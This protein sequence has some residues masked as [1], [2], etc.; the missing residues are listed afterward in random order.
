MKWHEEAL[1]PKTRQAADVLRKSGV[2]LGFYLVGGT[3]LALQFGHRFSEDLDF[4]SLSHPLDAIQR[5]KILEK[6]KP[7]GKVE[8]QHEKDGWLQIFLN[9]MP[10]TFLSYPYPLLEG[11]LDWDGVAVTSLEDIAL[12][13]INAIVGRGTKRDFLDLYA[14]CRQKNL[15]SLLALA[16]KKFPDHRDFLVQASYALVYFEDAEKDKM[17]RLIWK[18]DWEKIKTFF[19]KEVPPIFRRLLSEKK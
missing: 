19:L 12:M 13:K 4:F 6:L 3:G 7:F 11:L 15:G 1:S 8:I 14:I 5:Q 2:H 18:L 10:V 9:Q 17:P 16:E